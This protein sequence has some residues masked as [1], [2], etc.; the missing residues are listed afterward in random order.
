[1]PFYSLVRNNHRLK[2]MQTYAESGAKKMHPSILQNL[3][4]ALHNVTQHVSW[5][6]GNKSGNKLIMNYHY[7]K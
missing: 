2:N 7:K 6:R 5:Q 3:M 1:M 4:V